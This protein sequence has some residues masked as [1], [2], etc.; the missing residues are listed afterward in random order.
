MKYYVKDYSNGNLIPVKTI[1]V[2]LDDGTIIPLEPL[3]KDP[4]DV[5][6]RT[7]K[8]KAMSINDLI[9][10]HPT[11]KAIIE[12]AINTCGTSYD[13]IDEHLEDLDTGQV[14]VLI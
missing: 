7:F 8:Y 2:E 6:L 1:Y 3:S 14:S 4:C 12:I 11:I 5:F 13:S 9:D 10:T